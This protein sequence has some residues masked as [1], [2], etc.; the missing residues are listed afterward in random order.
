MPNGV[1]SIPHYTRR[2]RPAQTPLIV[3][4]RLV[5][6]HGPVARLRGTRAAVALRYQLPLA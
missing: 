4:N 5:V 2:W 6:G 1:A 3:G